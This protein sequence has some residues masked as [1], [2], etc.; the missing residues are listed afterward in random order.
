MN[1]FADFATPKYLREKVIDEQ[2]EMTPRKR[3]AVQDA[4]DGDYPVKRLRF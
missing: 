1:A 2:E 3:Q 4:N